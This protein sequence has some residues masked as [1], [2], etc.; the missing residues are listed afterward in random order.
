[1]T[2]RVHHFRVWSISQGDY[3]APPLKATEEFI[4]SAK[5]EIVPGTAEDIDPGLLDF[6]GRY[7]PQRS[8]SPH[9]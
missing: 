1:M 5:G 4:R 6:Q 8:S 3:V 2:V 7:D 9:P